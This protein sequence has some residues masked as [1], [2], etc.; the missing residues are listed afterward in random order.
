VQH[1]SHDTTIELERVETP[2]SDTDRRWPRRT[3]FLVILGAGA[4]CWAIP[5][6]IAYLLLYW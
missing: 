2:P 5:A 3:R 6:M 1:H 4:L